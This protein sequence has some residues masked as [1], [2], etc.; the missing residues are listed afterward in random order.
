MSIDTPAKRP[1]NSDASPRS[2]KRVARKPL[3]TQQRQSL[4]HALSLENGIDVAEQLQRLT[5]GQ[6]DLDQIDWSSQ[7]LIATAS[8]SS[9]LASTSSASAHVIVRYPVPQSSKHSLRPSHLYPH[10]PYF[11]A[12]PLAGPS[13]PRTSSVR[14]DDP[15]HVAF[16]PCGF[17][18]CAYF[19]AQPANTPSASLPPSLPPLP[20]DAQIG[21]NSGEPMAATASETS[22]PTIN[23]LSGALAPLDASL[24]ASTNP[25]VAHTTAAASLGSA[26]E[27]SGVFCIW[28]RAETAALNDWKLVD[29]I[30]VDNIQHPAPTAAAG[31]ADNVLK[32]ND[33]GQQILKD[34]SRASPASK[35]GVHLHAGVAKV[36][37]LN[38]RR[39]VVLS[40]A[41]SATSHYGGAPFERLSSRGPT[42][43]PAATAPNDE[44]GPDKDLALVVFGQRG[45]V[46]LLC[47][48][49]ANTND[50]SVDTA[51]ARTKFFTTVLQSDLH[52]PRV[53]PSPITLDSS[54]GTERPDGAGSA[55]ASLFAGEADGAE[56]GMQYAHDAR[57]SHL[58]VGMPA[59][60]PVLLVA[61]K[62][63]SAAAALVDLAEITV[64]LRADA[65]TMTTRPLQPIS[66]TPVEPASSDGA[67]AEPA[68]GPRDD[69]L[70]LLTW[71]EV[72]AKEPSGA[73][74]G[75][76]DSLR[77]LACWSHLDAASGEDKE[78]GMGMHSSLAVWDL[79]KAETELSEAFATLECRKAGQAPA[80]LDWQ[81]RF[82]GAKTL[83][84][85]LVTSLVT[86]RAL[87]GANTAILTSLSAAQGKVG[88]LSEQ[89]AMVDLH[90]LELAQRVP[91]PPR[92]LLR[93]SRPV[94]SANG[95]LI[96]VFAHTHTGA[97]AAIV[98]WKLPWHSSKPATDDA[99]K[100]SVDGGSEERARMVQLLALSCVRAS[101]ASDISRVY[102][103]S[104]GADDA[105]LLVDVADVLK[106]TDSKR[107]DVLVKIEG[108]TAK[109]SSHDT[110]SIPFHQ[111]LRLLKIRMAIASPASP[112]V[113]LQKLVLELSLCYQVLRLARVSTQVATTAKDDGK[114]KGKPAGGEMRPRVYYR[115]ESVWP[116]LAQLQWL[117]GLLDGVSKLSLA[118][119][120]AG[121]QVDGDSTR[122]EVFEEQFVR[123]LAK[124]TPRRLVLHIVAHL[125][126]FV[127]WVESSER[128]ENLPPPTGASV[129]D[130]I[131][132]LA[133]AATRGVLA[134]SE[135]MALAREA[136]AHIT[137]SAS[138]DLADFAHLLAS[139][140][141]D[142][143]AAPTARAR[144]TD[145]FWWATLGGGSLGE[146]GEVKADEGVPTK[147][148]G[149]LGDAQSGA[150][151]D[152][153][154][155]FIVP[156]DITDERS[157]L[158][159]ASG[160]AAHA[161]S[162]LVEALGA[163]AAKRDSTRDVMRKTTLRAA[164]SQS[165]IIN[166]SATIIRSSAPRTST[167]GEVRVDLM[168]AKRCVRCGALSQDAVHATYTM[169][170]PQP[171]P[172][173]MVLDATL[174]ANV[175]MQ[176]QMQVHMHM[177]QAGLP[178]PPTMAPLPPP[179][180]VGIEAPDTR[181][182]SCLCGGTWWVL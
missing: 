72:D 116:L 152:V 102:G 68:G 83:R 21:Q 32:V 89:L 100:P 5:R 54:T 1:R 66:L 71:A 145:R 16:S 23:Q 70:T 33:K 99:T 60:E 98:L 44:A 19:P 167:E 169:P 108:A 121:S 77:L 78:D 8:P 113:R 180:L 86:P 7:N 87:V 150:L 88:L 63:T 39:R 90:T 139:M 27:P 55:Y 137:R 35:D 136:L 73:A 58:A 115:L 151:V 120:A 94:V 110:N 56:D 132:F 29:S 13:Q 61:S 135:Q 111:A 92:A 18:L 166:D 28:S 81:L 127:Q 163:M 144:E 96:A 173:G 85:Q 105:K 26:S 41:S 177:V 15:R 42:Y 43:V 156:T 128:A 11:S 20:S 119:V 112:S 179:A 95:A 122:G 45:Q 138:I 134:V 125:V 75:K 31:K 172:N 52:T 117:L 51:K 84:G 174:P 10:Q 22:I 34:G 48:R 181:T 82:A 154:P 24:A 164:V 106:I 80:W 149:L 142:S 126:D 101:D 158:Y 171:L 3:S 182:R 130:E 162:P 57:I 143:G 74:A 17:Y 168:R 109:G 146:Q 36:V 123:M 67:T 14:Y 12:T 49:N 59:N 141:A 159:D 161:A 47:R 104:A 170:A 62:R 2:H 124:P 178:A 53:Q 4:R 50:S 9:S 160:D 25:S 153:L 147:L 131:G 93:C 46:T 30:P 38:Q 157:V 148:L 129:G 114:K 133:N 97:T 37:W 69:A 79:Y 91:V 40:T 65:V 140:E 176:M 6:A 155:L 107:Q 64:D 175:Q 165:T 103:A 76:T 118:T